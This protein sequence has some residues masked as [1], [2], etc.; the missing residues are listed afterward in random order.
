M[1]AWTAAIETTRSDPS[2]SQEHATALIRLGMLKLE[3]GR[4][5][6][7]E[8]LLTD[9]ITFVERHLG[10]DHRSLAVALNELSRLYVRQKDFA[11][12]EPMLRRLVQITRAKG[13]YPKLITGSGAHYQLLL[14]ANTN[15]SKK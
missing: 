5:D 15:F 11:R 14:A 3:L 6:E 7:A 13:G 4:R 12:A 2:L 9:A 8:K 1:E 10:A